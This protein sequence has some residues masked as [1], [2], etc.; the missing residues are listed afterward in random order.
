MFLW[1]TMFCFAAVG[2]LPATVPCAQL[3][4]TCPIVMLAPGE[5]A[6]RRS[7]YLDLDANG[8][9]YDTQGTRISRD[10]LTGIMRDASRDKP[11][12][13]RRLNIVLSLNDAKNTPISMLRELLQKMLEDAGPGDWGRIYVRGVLP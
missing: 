7:L 8:A 4:G 3:P 1:A 6:P 11:R 9:L 13:Q 10:L 5:R 2:P 12:P